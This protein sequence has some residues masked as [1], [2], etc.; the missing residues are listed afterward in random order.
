MSF[1]LSFLKIKKQ[2]VDVSSGLLRTLYTNR[3]KARGFSRTTKINGQQVAYS[4]AEWSWR[5]CGGEVLSAREPRAK[6]TLILAPRAG[7]SYFQERG[8][9]FCW[10]HFLIQV[11]LA[12]KKRNIRNR[13][14]T[15]RPMRVRGRARGG[16]AA[17][18][19][20]AVSATVRAAINLRLRGV[21][22]R[23][24]GLDATSPLRRGCS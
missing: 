22:I 9:S 1:L 18:S 3:E 6:S 11:C 14:L 5:S 2:K 10:V 7:C 20:R 16:G 13:R 17:R 12:Y 8:G 4:T 24:S 21:G 15:H 23:A 19:A